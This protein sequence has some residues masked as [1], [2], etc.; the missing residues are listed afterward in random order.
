M[1]AVTNV[2]LEVLTEE[3]IKLPVHL[4]YAENRII[5]SRLSSLFEGTTFPAKEFNN[6][7]SQYGY[8]APPGATILVTYALTSSDK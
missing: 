3:G 7:Y 2:V 5:S 8:T 4:E 1:A 6:L